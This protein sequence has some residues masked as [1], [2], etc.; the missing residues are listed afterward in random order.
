MSY[1]GRTHFFT[2]LKCEKYMQMIWKI[3]KKFEIWQG[4]IK[5]TNKKN[6]NNDKKKKNHR[7]HKD[8]GNTMIYIYKKNMPNFK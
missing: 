4:K 6:N 8:K 3:N 1:S 7:T 5:Q 2:F